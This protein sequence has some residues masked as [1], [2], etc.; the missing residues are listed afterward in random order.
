MMDLPTTLPVGVIIHPYRSDL[1]QMESLFVEPLS[2]QLERFNVTQQMIYANDQFHVSRLRERIRRQDLAAAVTFAMGPED[3]TLV[4]VLDASLPVVMVNPYKVPAHNA[5]LPDDQQGVLQACELMALIG[6]KRVLY[7]ANRTIHYSGALRKQALQSHLKTL[8]IQ[9]AGEFDHTNLSKQPLSRLIKRHRV[10][11][12]V[13]Y[14]NVMAR[15]VMKLLHEMQIQVP[16]DMN[17]LSLAGLPGSQ[18]DHQVTQ[19]VLPFD[20]MGRMAADL[21]IDMIKHRQAKFQNV[22]VPEYLLLGRTCRR[23]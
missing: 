21:C 13:C 12:I 18:V 17:V 20:Q 3:D 19:I 16:D 23:V 9:M 1:N 6:A 2:R 10:D 7:I 22:L 15:R 8:G 14:N 4:N 11:S 5:V